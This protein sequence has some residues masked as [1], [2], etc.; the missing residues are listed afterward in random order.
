MKVEG[1]IPS[2]IKGENNFEKTFDHK[3]KVLYYHLKNAIY[4]T[5]A[6]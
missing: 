6:E 1:E 4:K 5:A 3:L 2:R